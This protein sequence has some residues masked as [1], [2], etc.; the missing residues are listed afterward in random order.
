M[1]RIYI[2][3]SQAC[4]AA[5]AG[6]LPAVTGSELYGLLVTDSELCRLPVTGSELWRLPVTDSEIWRLPV[7]RNSETIPNIVRTI[8]SSASDSS[9][10]HDK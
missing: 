7:R 3:P 6:R 8:T 4:N 5:S 1:Q 10:D 9:Q 2:E